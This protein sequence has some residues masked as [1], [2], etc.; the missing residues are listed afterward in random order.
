MHYVYIDCFSE[1]RRSTQLRKNSPVDNYY[2]Q[3]NDIFNY[4]YWGEY[5]T[6]FGM[7]TQSGYNKR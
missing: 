6:F 3:A 1:T 4:Y 5:G 2:Y 7:Q